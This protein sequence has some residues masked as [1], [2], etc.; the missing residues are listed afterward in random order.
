MS[1]IKTFRCCKCGARITTDVNILGMECPICE[2]DGFKICHKSVLVNFD[3]RSEIEPSIPRAKELM[4]YAIQEGSLSENLLTAM[5]S[6]CAKCSEVKQLAENC[7]NGCTTQD[8][9]VKAH[10]TH[11]DGLPNE[12]QN[13]EAL[14][15]FC[16]KEIKSHFT[17][18]QEPTTKA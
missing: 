4:L 12:C 3:E 9:L 10:F 7:S 14:S 16:T 17:P 5:G 8:K 11:I 15:D 1:Y 18:E 13:C 6:F 2:G